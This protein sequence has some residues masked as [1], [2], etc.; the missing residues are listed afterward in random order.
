M[1]PAGPI[2]SLTPVEERVRQYLIEEKAK[3]ANAD[4]PFQATITYMDLCHAIDPDQR[5]WAYPRFRGI[6]P[7]LGRISTFEHQQGRP[8]LSGLV[9]HS[10]DMQ[11]G[12]GFAEL[13][14]GLGY[15]I[16]PGQ[17]RGFWRSQV[18]ALVQYWT[19][20]GQD[21]VTASSTERA[22]ALLA[23][24]SEELKEVRRLLGAA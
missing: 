4:H 13:A 24:I 10:S 18:E 1:C 8:L 14:R 22:L 6:G 5:Y 19:G 12:N 21:N 20:A 2:S 7:V 3:K 11:A 15:Q 9:V 23:T 16:Q 17:E